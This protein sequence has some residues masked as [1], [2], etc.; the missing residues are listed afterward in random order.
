MYVQAKSQFS[1][2]E[3]MAKYWNYRYDL[4]GD[5]HPDVYSFTD[6]N[7]DGIDDTDPY[8]DWETG[9][10]EITLNNGG[11]LP[12][13]DQSINTGNWGAS[14]SNAV[15]SDYVS[16]YGKPG[17]CANQS[18]I[19]GG[20]NPNIFGLLSW[21]DG[22]IQ[23]GKYMMILATEWKLLHDNE[24]NTE[25][26]E[27]EIYHAVEAAIRLDEMGEVKFGELPLRNGFFARDD[28]PEGFALNG[29]P[30]GDRVKLIASDWSCDLANH[31][32]DDGKCEGGNDATIIGT[33]EPQSGPVSTWNMKASTEMS[34]DQVIYH[35]VGLYYIAKT[36]PL[37]LSHSPDPNIASEAKEQIRLIIEYLCENEWKIKNPDG[38]KVCRGP[39]AVVYGYILNKIADDLSLGSTPCI[40]EANL[41]NSRKAWNILRMVY[42]M[43]G[44]SNLPAL[45]NDWSHQMLTYM[46]MLD[47]PNGRT[48]HFIHNAVLLSA[49]SIALYN[50]MLPVPGISRLG[51][52]GWAVKLRDIHP[53]NYEDLSWLD[54]G[55]AYIHTYTPRLPK[56]YYDS[57]MGLSEYNCLK[58][59]PVEKD[60]KISCKIPYD[61]MLMNNLTRL[62]FPSVMYQY[63]DMAT[64][65]FRNFDNS[66]DRVISIS[67]PLSGG[68]G[69]TSKPLHIQAANSLSVTFGHLHYNCEMYYTAP[70]LEFYP[71]F[72]TVYGALF[73]AKNARMNCADIYN[74][75]SVYGKT[76]TIPEEDSTL[77]ISP[78][79]SVAMLDWLTE[80]NENYI[81]PA[82]GDVAE[83]AWNY[84][85]DLLEEEEARYTGTDKTS[86]ESILNL[87]ISPNPST[88]THQTKASF[89]LP[90]ATT[91]SLTIVDNVGHSK[92]IIKKKEVYSQGSYI[93][94][95]PISDLAAGIY[96][97]VL[98]TERHSTFAKLVVE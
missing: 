59:Q 12:A 18:V 4:I 15:Y 20:N 40:D 75:G 42:H 24:Q 17:Q 13:V 97:V 30:F 3:N 91:I 38:N 74:D 8:N 81:I 80:M 67:Y 71:G 49:T 6:N 70:H 47:G 52:A 84:A 39:S 22:Q 1:N 65:A 83:A 26:V 33:F 55:G 35:L 64:G 10:L 7:N 86:R 45:G 62:T 43:S 5:E 37:G 41:I 78:E 82:D 68:Y 48:D 29:T 34:M 32:D 14:N 96:S 90:S 57:R 27:K 23:F 28:V 77:V 54:A 85:E 72:Q 11:S 60:G 44:V 79:D 93:T 88:S 94:V 36:I 63:K 21:G 56:S 53:E 16:Y 50:I 89:Y 58:P 25:Q 66:Y 19:P 9:F 98:Q 69:S 87:T 76:D 46:L 2:A 51:L 95:I 31:E 73:E 92:E 61:F